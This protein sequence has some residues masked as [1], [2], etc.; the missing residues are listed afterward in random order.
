MK[1]AEEIYTE[2]GGYDGNND[3]ESVIVMMKE[4]AKQECVA[5]LEKLKEEYDFYNMSI[6]DA[7]AEEIYR[8]YEESKDDI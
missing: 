7:D 3:K 8:L 1:T 4:Y 6:K 2:E 5:F